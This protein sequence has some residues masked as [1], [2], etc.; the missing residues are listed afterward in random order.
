M[1]DKLDLRP[2]E[3]L[4]AYWDEVVGIEENAEFLEAERFEL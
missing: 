2:S 3:V 4:E 1:P